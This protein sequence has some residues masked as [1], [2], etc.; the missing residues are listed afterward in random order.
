MIAKP[1]QQPDYQNC[2]PCFLGICKRELGDVGLDHV[3]RYEG[4]VKCLGCGK[5]PSELE[6]YR[7]G[8][9]DP[10]VTPEQFVKE[11]EGTYAI[12]GPGTF[13]CT[14]CYIRAGMPLNYSR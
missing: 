4:P 12:K 1:T 8:E 13:Y 14:P 7:A 2:M 10:G 3:Y 5:S 9:I 6:E 11:E